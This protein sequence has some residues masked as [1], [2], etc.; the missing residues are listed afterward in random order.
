MRRSDSPR[1]SLTPA[2]ARRA[3]LWGQGLVAGGGRL[4]G[5]DVTAA[6]GLLVGVQ[7]DPYPAI[8][9]NH[10]L[11]LWNRLPGFTEND[12]ERA[13]Y[14]GR[15][16][17]ECTALKRNTFFVRT[18]DLALMRAATRGVSRWGSSSAEEARLTQSEP[19]ARK[20]EEAVLAAFEAFGPMTRERLWVVMG[21]EGD[22]R[23]RREEARSG[24]VRSDLPQASRQC[25]QAFGRLLRQGAIVVTSRL[26]GTFRPPVYGLASRFLPESVSDEPDEASA[27]RWLTS[28]LLA[29]YGVAPPSLLTFVT[30]LP[31]AEVRAVLH[32]ISIT[33]EAV[34]AEVRGLGPGGRALA[35]WASPQA[36]DAS[37]SVREPSVAGSSHVFLLPPLDNLMRYRP[38]IERLFGYTFE[39]EYFRKKGMRW[40]LSCL[41]DDAFAGW[42][43]CVADRRAHA[44][45]VRSSELADLGPG[46]WRA[47]KARVDELARFHGAGRGEWNP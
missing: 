30:G 26:P 10:Y 5:A 12:L 37:S 35:V 47:V 22:W 40:Q 27:K 38:W 24:T 25:F 45:R 16:V 21:L 8:S 33:G 28:A 44:F 36:L 20:A 1:L 23:K 31:A 2:Q 3:L 42:I 43:D 17:T 11:V 13:A 39:M 7:Y 41:I 15:S 4:A 9:Q 6:V 19:E 32:E 14:E 46:P 34:S 18:C 29:S